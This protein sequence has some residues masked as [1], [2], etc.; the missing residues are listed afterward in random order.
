MRSFFALHKDKHANTS[1]EEMIEILPAH[2]YARIAAIPR[3]F[4][5]LGLY[6]Q[7][8]PHKPK[9]WHYLSIILENFC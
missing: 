4:H 9:D 1:N 8:L 5:I 7:L 3:I 6:A 2:L